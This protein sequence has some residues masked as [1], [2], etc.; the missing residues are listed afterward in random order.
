MTIIEEPTGTQLVTIDEQKLRRRLLAAPEVVIFSP[1]LDDAILSCGSLLTDLADNRVPLTIINVFTRGSSLVTPLNQRLLR[2]AGFPDA[3][4][5][6]AA[7]KEEDRVA[8]ENLPGIKIIN[9]DCTDAPWRQAVS[10]KAL[11]ETVFDDRHTDDVAV[12]AEI[13]EKINQHFFHPEAAII[14]PLGCGRHVDHLITR[15]VVTDL[16]AKPIYYA[17]FPY[18]LDNTYEEGFIV[19]RSLD[20]FKWHGPYNKKKE[21]ILSYKSQYSSFSSR[22]TTQ[23]VHETYCLAA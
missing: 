19:E 16:I 12:L 20:Q 10:G 3:E 7:R 8:L 21:L 4:Q 17:D 23:L 15:D 13:K 5:Y 18:V 1:H 9:L 14:G 2:Q 22:P 11:Y 6:F